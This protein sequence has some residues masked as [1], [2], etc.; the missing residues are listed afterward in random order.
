MTWIWGIVLVFLAAAGVWDL[1][2]KSVPLWWLFL[3][4]DLAAAVTAGRLAAGECSWVT[5]GLSLAPGILLLLLSF[6]TRQGVGWGDGLAALAVG[7]LLGPALLMELMTAALFMSA[8]ISAVLLILHRAR[9]NTRIPF[10]PM[11][12]SAAVF[13]VALHP[14]T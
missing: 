4:A 6:I 2:T 5:V 10:L 9:K 14:P 13:I 8:A 7:A 11:M 3:G 1:R 12:A